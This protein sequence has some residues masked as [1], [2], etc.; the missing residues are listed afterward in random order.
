MIRGMSRGRPLGSRFR[1][2]DGTGL[3]KV[4][5][6]PLV[7]SLSNHHRILDTRPSTSSGL[8]VSFPKELCTEGPG[9]T[10]ARVDVGIARRLASR[11]EWEISP[12]S[13]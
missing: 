12:E 7:V 1:G 11:C 10:G 8:T 2:N 6:N 3:C 9:I 5:E 13:R 4:F